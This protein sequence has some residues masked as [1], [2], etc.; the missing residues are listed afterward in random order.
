MTHQP[1]Q[2]H[3]PSRVA[4]GALLAGCFA[5]TPACSTD[6][7]ALGTVRTPQA[8]S[9]AEARTS[10]ANDGK[11]SGALNGYAWVAAG[12]L[13]TVESPHPCNDDGCF[14]N[15]EEGLC[16]QGSMPALTCQGNGWDCNYADN[17]GV[18]VGM[19]PAGEHVEW[20][21]AAPQTVA[22]TYTGGAGTYR[23]SAHVAGDPEEKDYCLDGYISG[24]AV[25]ASNLRS[26]CWGD[27]GEPLPSF[28]IVDR[29]GLMMTSAKR[30]QTFD[31]CVSDVTVNAPADTQRVPIGDN[32]K[33]SGALSG[34]S[35]VAGSDGTAFTAPAPCNET[36]CFRDTGGQ[37]CAQGTIEA[38]EC[39]GSVAA[40][41]Y[42]CNWAQNWGG[43]IGVNTT[44]AHTA[45]GDH[46]REKISF[47]YSGKPGK[48][49]LMAHVAGD[50]HEKIY[51]IRNYASGVEVPAGMFRTECWKS[52]GIPLAHFRD[53]D[54]FGL[55]ILS[56][57]HPVD[58]D[59]CVS[60]ITAG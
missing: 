43:L 51:C 31:I 7:P 54:S 32:G 1:T 60:T 46:A 13:A 35:W 10:F 19:N 3:A 12:K 4:L 58:F 50:P 53:V 44:A 9:T 36:G 8:V 28:A 24:L 48:Y 59:Y 40:G 30:N 39:S 33:L 52:T 42:T 17:W 26:K 15:T 23:L 6:D 11:L 27:D 16:T 25:R 22:I 21:A 29:I 14:T 38:L 49:Q 57:E 18:M 37:L 20:G 56:E 47:V 55:M 45:W 5:A 34:D 41:D 2:I